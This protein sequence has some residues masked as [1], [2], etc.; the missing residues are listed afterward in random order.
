MSS[1]GIGSRIVFLAIGIL[2][3][4]FAQSVHAEVRVSGAADAV[5]IETR[6]ATLEEVLRALQGSVKFRYHSTG[7]LDGNVSGTYS[8]PLRRVIARLLE[9]Y[10]YVVRSSPNELQIEI[11]GSSKHAQASAPPQASTSSAP[12]DC[13][14]KDGDRVIPVEC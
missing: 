3:F 8:G 10:N 6:G 4:G 14:Y 7:A 2:C 12:K 11:L 5:V 1:P 9:N 13:Q